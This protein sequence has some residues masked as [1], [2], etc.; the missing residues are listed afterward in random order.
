MNLLTIPEIIERYGISRFR[1]MRAVEAGELSGRKIGQTWAFAQNDLE[2][3]ISLLVEE[4]SPVSEKELR[5]LRGAMFKSKLSQ[6][7]LARKFEVSP[8][9]ISHVLAGRAP[10]SRPRYRQIMREISPPEKLQSG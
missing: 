6:A 5:K 9:Y 3:F 4:N 7:D 8:S 1:I 10:V 2:A